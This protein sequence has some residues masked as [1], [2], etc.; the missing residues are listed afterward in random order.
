MKITKYEHACFTVEHEGKLLV[1]DP[2][3]FTTN[4]G[5]PENVVG[6]VVTHEHADHFDPAALGALIAHNPDALVIAHKNITRQFGDH[7]ETL[8]YQSVAA[9]E[10]FDVGPF[11]LEFFGGEHA[12]IHPDMPVVANLGVMINDAIFYPG[13]SFVNPGKPVRV[14]ALPVGAPWLKIQEV[15]DYTRKVRPSIAFPT[16]DAVLSKNGKALPDRI[17]PH[18]TEHL[19]IIYQRIDT[20]PL[21]V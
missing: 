3:A 6:I 13:D 14:L 19:G 16:H 21:E 12:V 7:D 17:V 11:H 1:V 10:T 4:I 20:A 8:P 18:L 15:I 2:G 5:S 9:G